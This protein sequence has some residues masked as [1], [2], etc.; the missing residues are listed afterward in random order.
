MK[1]DT[2][3]QI[4]LFVRERINSASLWQALK[5]HFKELWNEK[6]EVDEQSDREEEDE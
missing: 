3:P 2:Q 1:S 4:M 5:R 6:V